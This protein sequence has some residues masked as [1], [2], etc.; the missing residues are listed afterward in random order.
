M[1]KKM[2]DDNQFFK[3]LRYAIGEILLVVVGILI[4][5]Q[6]NN[7]ND[8]RKQRA[9]LDEYLIKISNNVSQDIEQIKIYQVRRDTVRS[10]AIKSARKIIKDDYTDIFTV[11]R[12]TLCFYEFYFI[13][14]KSGFDALKNSAYLGKINNTRLDSLLMSYYAQIDKIEKAELSYNTFIEN[15]ESELSLEVDQSSFMALLSA[16]D[17]ENILEVD[18]T[19]SNWK[20]QYLEKVLPRIKHNAFKAAVLRTVAERT[21]IGY[22]PKVMEIGE[23]LREEID[24]F[25]KR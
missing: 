10:K 2:A 1:R 8:L 22:Y 20:A 15:M 24:R 3:Y 17:D 9:E 19:D 14:N 11:L 21:Y 16:R 5:L 23:A 7:A 4:A 6:I 13:P 25:T 12:G 18:T